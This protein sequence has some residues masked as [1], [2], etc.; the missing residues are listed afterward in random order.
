MR[1]LLIGVLAGALLAAAALT[2]GSTGALAQ[3]STTAPGYNFTIN[4]YITNKGV[5][6][7][8]SVAK[9]GWLAHF[10]IHNHSSKTV[11]F[12]V[13]GLKSKKIPPGKTGKVGAYL[14]DRGQFDYKVDNV[15]RGYFQ[16][17]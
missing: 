4:V 9:R 12:E 14:D 11:Q 13:G 7:D 6:L 15:L 2:V 16:V 10:L 3:S 8:R 5:I 17:V 1:K